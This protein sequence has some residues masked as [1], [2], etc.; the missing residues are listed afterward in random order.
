MIEQESAAFLAAARRGLDPQVP[1]CPDWDVRALVGHLGRTHRY[2]ASHLVRG[3]TDPPATPSPEP[4][5]DDAEL[6]RW[7]QEGVDV[8]LAAVRETDPDAP[9]WTWAPHVA[10]VAAFWPRRMALETAVHR[11]DAQAAHGDADPV[12]AEVADDGVDEV[13]AVHRPADW[14][15]EPVTVQGVVAVRLTDTATE[16]VVQVSPTGIRATRAKP[17]AVLAGSASDVLLALWGRLP[18]A[19]LVT[20]DAALV[21]ALR[22]S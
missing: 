7:F 3:V 21:D 14:D 8:L 4:P 22:T 11:W 15:D 9:A 13:L 18:L 12:A 5:G 17:D 16:H 1:S 10:P 6:V 2:H 19:P 20:G